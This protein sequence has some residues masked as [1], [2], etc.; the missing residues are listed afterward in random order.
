MAIV[1]P[2]PVALDGD[3]P[4]RARH[5][6]ANHARDF[7]RDPALEP[8][9]NDDEDD[10]HRDPDDGVQRQERPPRLAELRGHRVWL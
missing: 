2:L 7:E 10:H 5:R 6:P 4:E 8:V 9:G 3:D 1:T